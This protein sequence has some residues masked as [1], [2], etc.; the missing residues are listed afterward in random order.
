MAP[1]GPALDQERNSDARR[2]ARAKPALERRNGSRW[3]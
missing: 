1:A 3:R 2:M